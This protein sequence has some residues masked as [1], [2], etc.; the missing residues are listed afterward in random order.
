MIKAKTDIENTLYKRKGKTFSLEFQRDL[1][2]FESNEL[3]VDEFY[4]KIATK[5]FP[6]MLTGSDVDSFQVLLPILSCLLDP[7]RR[8]TLHL[9]F[10]RDHPRCFTNCCR[11]EHCFKCKVKLYLTNFT[12]IIIIINQDKGMASGQD[13]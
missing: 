9:R 5:Y 10:L 12:H 7:E 1:A 11:R 2:K 4:D 13:L 8:S 3:N 6:S